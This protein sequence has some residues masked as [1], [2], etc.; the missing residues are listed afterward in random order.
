MSATAQQTDFAHF[1]RGFADAIFSGPIP[2]AIEYATGPAHVSRFN[3]YRNNV[4]AG[5][6]GA[7]AA[8][9]P[10]VKRLLWNDAFERVAYRYAVST[11]PR[12]PV[13]L[14]YGDSFPQFLREVGQCTSANY[15]ADVA[16]LER[17]RTRAYH[18]AD[19]VPLPT[20]AFSALATEGLANL[21]LRLHPSVALLKSRFP[22]V[23]IWR[24]TMHAND[25]AIRQWHPEFALIARPRL[26]VEV[27]PIPAGVFE[28]LGAI[29]SGASIGD[30]V[31]RTDSSVSD[32]DLAGCFATMIASRIAVGVETA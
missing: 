24:V 22:V 7:I 15:A 18:A 19:A 8:R 23:S 26:D 9:Y 31:A 16:E 17:L 5:L 1:Q 30:A 3:V 6:I 20:E 11:P 29:A 13:L 12:S 14:E 32:F 25:N 21:R 27:R 4:I 10:A 28:F 2:E